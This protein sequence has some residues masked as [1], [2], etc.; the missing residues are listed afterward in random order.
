MNKTKKQ[1]EQLQAKINPLQDKIYE[2]ENEETLKVQL[3]RL[4]KMV[5]YCLRSTYKP[6]TYYGKILDLVE[7]KDKRLQF[8]LEVCHITE[9]GNPYIHLDAISPYLNKEWWDAEVPINGWEKCPEE[10]YQTFK[11]KILGEFNS[12]KSLRKWI[13]NLKY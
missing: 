7:E 6:E 11:A 13:R 1:I 12:Q 10:E 9:E 3:P 8:I 4:I 5:G 2:L